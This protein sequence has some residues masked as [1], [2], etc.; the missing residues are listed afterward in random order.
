MVD[1]DPGILE[2]VEIILNDGGFETMI[3]NDALKAEEAIRSFKPDLVMLDIWMPKISGEDLCR[4]IKAN[5]ETGGMPVI[6]L[7]ASNRTEKISLECGADSY[8]PKPFDIEDLI[9]KIKQ[10]TT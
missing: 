1:D 2:V 8:L 4:R 3:L 10:M 9:G 6:L 7:S 5:P